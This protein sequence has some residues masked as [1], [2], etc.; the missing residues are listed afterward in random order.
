MIGDNSE[1]FVDRVAEVGA[2]V[3]G[4]GAD[5]AVETRESSDGTYVS[6]TLTVV[7]DSAGAILEIYEGF[8]GIDETRVVL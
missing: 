8:D 1:E 7:V 2:D 4:D 5:P 6:V 3:V